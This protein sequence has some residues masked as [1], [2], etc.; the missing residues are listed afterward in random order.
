MRWRMLIAALI[1]CFLIVGV[2]VIYVYVINRPPFDTTAPIVI[3]TS[4]SDGDS[5]AGTVTI[6]FTATD[7]TFI[8]ETEIY[9]DNS[10]RAATT[11]YMWNT[12]AEKNGNH[13]ILCRAGDSSGNWGQAVI[14]IVVNNSP[15][16]P[17]PDENVTQTTY[18]DAFKVMSYNIEESGANENWKEVVKEENPDILVL[19][20]TGTFDDNGNETLDEIVS[21]FNTYFS[22]ELPYE[23]YCTQGISY[24]TDGEAILSRFPVIEFKQI[25]IVKLDNGSNYDVTHDFV[26]A[27]VNVSGTDMHVI[28]AHLK[29]RDGSSNEWRRERET[30]GIINYMDG[31]GNVPILY[32]GD[33]NSFSPDDTGSLAPHGDLGY[34][35]MT[36]MLYPNDPT[37]GQYASAVHNFTDVFR[38]LNP[39]DPGYTYGHQDAYYLSRIDFLVTNQ[40]FSGRLI[41]STV[42]DTPSA[43]TGSDHYC[44]DV[45][46]RANLTTHQDHE[47]P[48]KVTGLTTADVSFSEINLS[49]TPNSESDISHYRIYRDGILLA[50]IYDN[51]YND[52]GLNQ[53]TSY[54]YEVS[55]VDTSLN[56]GPR[57]DPLNV[58]TTSKGDPDLVVINE[59][60]PDPDTVYSDEWIELYN[61]Q[62]VDANISGYFLDDIA[63]NGSN[64]YLI[65]KGTVISAH[66][67]LVF[68]KSTTGI[69]L[70]NV[71]DTVNLIRPD[72]ITIIDTYEYNSTMNDIS[73]GRETDGGDTWT[74]FSFPTPG[75]SN[76]NERVPADAVVI[77]E[78]LP[79]PNTLYTEE[80]IE[81]YNP[82]NESVDISRY[83]LD[84]IV[85]GGSG[86][87]TIPS[88]TIIPANGFALFNYTTTGIA[89]NNAG[90]NVTL[91]RPNYRE[92]IDSYSYNSSTSDVSIG[93]ITDGNA[94]WTTF[95]S[96]TP[97]A[98]NVHSSSAAADSICINEFLPD[99]DTLYSEEWIELYNP[100]NESVDLSG[101]ILDDI[102]GGGSSP[103]T[104]PSGTIIPAFGFILFNQ[105][106]TGIAL[107]NAGDTVNFLKPDGS[108]VVDSH[109]YNSSTDDVSIGRTTDGG[110]NWTTF[111]APTP[112]ASNV[113]PSS[114]ADAVVI[115]EFLP[116]PDTAYSEEWIELYNPLNESVD[117]SGYIL[118]DIT[119]GGS[120]PYTI[121]QGTIIS[122]YGFA[123]FNQSTTGIALNN[124]GDTVNFLSPNGTVL[125]SYTYNSSS[126]DVSYGRST[127]GNSTWKTFASPTPG[128]SNG[129]SPLL[130]NDMLLKRGS[131]EI[132][133]LR[134]QTS[135][136]QCSHKRGPNHLEERLPH[137]GCDYIR[138]SGN[139][140]W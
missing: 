46:I 124:A 41:N 53:S 80:W 108:T 118:D 127:D 114:N 98:S 140:I 116:D 89:L 119:S 1:I 132:V 88:G 112:G 136:E 120:S 26:D 50:Q 5:L 45:F 92:I 133:D 91:L 126:N 42:G 22:N 16:S 44:V 2:V 105:S 35:P 64:P 103:Y 87:Y 14:T 15:P 39:T 70:N 111:I 100:L 139:I 17:P 34:G 81:L 21:E 123:L 66:G 129:A 76:T 104:I 101:Y 13:S 55:A 94:T 11:T 75:A 19:I 73:I 7:E 8:N 65:P 33:L 85:T 97:G 63:I 95:V 125:D 117:I 107:N 68:Y 109:A 59:F 18:T 83:I 90:D 36:M 137:R 93:R 10:L 49:W 56:E 86:P 54:V 31:L 47:P 74:T 99:P 27:V 128:A 121:P 28:G 40:F 77:N 134:I 110:A 25:P 131:P 71:N 29:A 4:P 69:N 51:T 37:Y 20:E 78:F 32:M 61:P 52:T 38:T 67:Y 57:S 113:V 9:I 138:D 6:S 30:E 135:T 79:S 58:S 82:L 23:G 96:P 12:T 106:T 84:D 48:A 122:A 130:S 3:I 72:G 60:L 62:D 115:N 43:D 102:T 24:S